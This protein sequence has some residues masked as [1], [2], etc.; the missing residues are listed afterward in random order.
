[1]FVITLWNSFEARPVRVCVLA[2]P[3][4]LEMLTVYHPV[5]VSGITDPDP[6]RSLGGGWIRV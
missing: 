5:V 2:L 1:V 4:F 3:F 6:I